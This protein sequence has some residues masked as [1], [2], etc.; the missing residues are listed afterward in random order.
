M[1]ARR[2]TNEIVREAQKYASPAEIRKKNPNLFKDRECVGCGENFALTLFGKG[3]NTRVF[4][5]EC[6]SHPD[7]D[8]RRL[9]HKALKRSLGITL[10][11]HEEMRRE[12][13][14]KCAACGDDLSENQNDVHTDHCHET[15]VVRGILCRHCNLAL[16]Y[17]SDS[18]A[19]L[20]LLIKYLEKP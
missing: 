10:H 5:D 6:R 18:I 1:G 3:W 7:Y 20:E 17:V 15:G 12:Q 9:K 2:K 4:C 19:R 16:G 14:D 11:Q 8:A 13:N